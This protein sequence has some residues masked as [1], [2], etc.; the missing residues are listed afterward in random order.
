MQDGQFRRG[1]VARAQMILALVVGLAGFAVG[2]AMSFEHMGW[3]MGLLF[4]WWPAA[5][6]GAGAAWVVGVGL[7]E[8]N[9]IL[10]RATLRR[11]P[12]N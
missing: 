5:V 4:G 10:A 9:G 2:W 3:R 6:L 8:L 11:P 12:P 1:H 7:P